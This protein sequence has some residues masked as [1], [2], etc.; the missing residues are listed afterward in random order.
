MEKFKKIAVLI[1]AENA[2]IDSIKPAITEVSKHGEILL[3]EAF[4]DWSKPQLMKWKSICKENY[5]VQKMQSGDA[6]GKNA[7]DIALVIRAVDLLYQGTFDAFAI[8]SSDSDYTPLIDRIKSNGVHTIIIGKKDQAKALKKRSS[9]FIAEEELV[10]P[11][12]KKTQNIQVTE[13]AINT[14]DLI[15]RAYR[16]APDK[17]R[18]SDGFIHVDYILEYIQNSGNEKEKRFSIKSICKSFPAYIK[19]HPKIYDFKFAGPKNQVPKFRLIIQAKN[20]KKQ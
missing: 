1:D 20:T 2:Q 18:D 15:K 8:I 7:T 11:K 14:D 17:K 6:K 5:I 16:D 9:I 10:I 3:K 12:S 19:L 4:G 13:S